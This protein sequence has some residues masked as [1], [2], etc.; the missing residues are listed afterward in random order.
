[1]CSGEIGAAILLVRTV[2]GSADDAGPDNS[3]GKRIRR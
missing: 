2:A 1:M 3:C